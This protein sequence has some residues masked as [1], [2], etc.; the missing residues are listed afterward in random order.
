MDKTSIIIIAAAYI[1]GSVPVGVVVARLCGGV[2]P[3][4]GGS[5]NIG[6]TNV[7]RTLGKG[8]GVATLIGDALKGALPVYVA[9]YIIDP[10]SPLTVSLAAFAAFLGHLF[11]VFLAFKGG[12]GVA[13]ALG[14]MVVISPLSTLICALIFVVV[15]YVSKYV[16]L[17]SMYAAVSMPLFLGLLTH[18]IEYVVLALA[19]AALIVFK[20]RA[21]IKR[22]KTGTENTIR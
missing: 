2:D 20:H 14:V 7:S 4:T 17:G 11:P 6:A 12:K 9:L 5:G 18:T 19:V 16:S 13:T 10:A 8:A 21:N 22:I 1:L 15:A 3:R